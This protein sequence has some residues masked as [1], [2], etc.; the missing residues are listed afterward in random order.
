MK[1]IQIIAALIVSACATAPRE[2]LLPALRDAPSKPVV[3]LV[4]GVT[5]VELR[6]RETGRI[7]WGNVASFFIPRD[8]GYSIALPIAPAARDRAEP[9]EVIRDIDLRVW[10][11]EVY[12]TLF[13]LMDAHGVPFVGHSYDW[14]EDL[15]TSAR[16]LILEIRKHDRVVLICQ[17]N[18]ASICR[19]AVKYGDVSLDEAERGMRRV[20][21]CVEKMILVGSSNGG[22]IRILRE[23]DRGRRYVPVAG[24]TMLPETLFTF[25]SL[26]T[27]LP[28]WESHW[29]V[30]AGGETLDVDLYDASDWVAQG[31]SIFDARVAARAPAEIFGTVE[32]RI[33]YLRT[34]LERAR[35]IQLLL[36]A[37]AGTGLPRIYS[38]QSAS[39][40]TPAGA[41]I[42]RGK[43]LFTGDA[44][45]GEET[46]RR[47]TS[48][49]DRHAT[50]ESQQSLGEDEVAAL[51]HP[52]VYVEQQHFEM[53]T[54]PDAQLWILRFLKE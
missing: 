19:W 36:R 22:A 42:V 46:L 54:H 2:P 29:F 26:F 48:P 51:T 13:R 18:A 7:L 16:S 32:E 28:S 33:E 31:W 5:G 10:R 12:G 8:G 11:K 40:S 35:R 45:L 23:I 30:D 39:F 21:T 27:D 4:P 44:G 47:I 17:S 14:R 24:R 49:G 6:D 50:R 25:R 15:I 52:H 38:I 41:A 9:G 43:T 53:I 1:L 37:D 34:Q 3:I 20:P